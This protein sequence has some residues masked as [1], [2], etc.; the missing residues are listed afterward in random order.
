MGTTGLA[1]GC[2]VGC[3]RGHPCCLLVHLGYLLGC[4]LAVDLAAVGVVFRY[5]RDIPTF[6]NIPR[7]TT[8]SYIRT[9]MLESRPPVSSSADGAS[10]PGADGEHEPRRPVVASKWVLVRSLSAMARGKSKRDLSSDSVRLLEAS[11]AGNNEM[12]LSLLRND[13]DVSLGGQDERGRTALIRAADANHT[14]TALLILR[15]GGAN[16]ELA[17]KDDSGRSAYAA[18]SLLTSSSGRGRVRSYVRSH[19]ISETH[20]I[21]ELRTTV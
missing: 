19:S 13:K 2:D 17:L 21:F 12:V 15:H 8:R 9:Y 10:L 14:T 1:G 3:V 18:R 5:K 4:Q 6:N 11:A 7:K 16:V 20:P